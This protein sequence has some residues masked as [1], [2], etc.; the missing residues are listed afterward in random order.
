MAIKLSGLLDRE[1]M[2]VESVVIKDTQ[3]FALY[4]LH[5]YRD[6]SLYIH[7]KITHQIMSA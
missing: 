7:L 4:N 1:M 3:I 6:S 5:T 2:N